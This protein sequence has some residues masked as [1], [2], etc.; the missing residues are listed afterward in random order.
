MEDFNSETDSDYTSYWRDWVSATRFCSVPLCVYLHSSS[1]DLLYMT[2]PIFL[3]FCTVFQQ[4]LYL[5]SS[6]LHYRLCMEKRQARRYTSTKSGTSGFFQSSDDSTTILSFFRVTPRLVFNPIL[7]NWC[8]SFIPLQI[9]CI[10]VALLQWIPFS[11][12]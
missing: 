12:L 2:Y 11:P 6:A 8:S 9:C 5:K 3:Y 7:I 4:P 10:L 1:L